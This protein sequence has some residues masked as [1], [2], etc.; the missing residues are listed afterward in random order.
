MSRLLAGVEGQA[1]QLV[2][3][4]QALVWIDPETQ[5]VRRSVSPP[6]EGFE[7]ELVLGELPAGARINYA[8]PAIPGLE[9]HLFVLSGCLN[10]TVE[11]DAHSLRPED[12]LRFRLF[13]TTQFHN[14]GP[15][16]VRYLIAITQP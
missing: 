14:P 9:E 12:C 16:R 13:G 3:A 8:A 1:P 11:G 6:A 4:D 2:R 10:L 7:T 5:F 15:S